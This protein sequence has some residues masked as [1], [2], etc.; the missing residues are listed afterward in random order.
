MEADNLIQIKNSYELADIDFE[1]DLFYEKLFCKMD[2]KE[3]KFYN[4]KIF[5]E[6]AKAWAENR[7][8][9]ENGKVSAEFTFVGSFS[10][11]EKNCSFRLRLNRK[12]RIFVYGANVKELLNELKKR[13][14]N[15]KTIKKLEKEFNNYIFLSKFL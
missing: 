13:N 1:F 4:V 15:L 10:F 3:I 14:V 11:R 7:K 2:K 8:F 12:N 9:F 6:T 5:D